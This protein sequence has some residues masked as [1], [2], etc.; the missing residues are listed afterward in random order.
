MQVWG[1]HR[2][3]LA[4]QTQQRGSAAGS[5]VGGC[6]CRDHASIVLKFACYVMQTCNCHVLHTVLQPSERCGLCMATCGTAT[7][8]ITCPL[9]THSDGTSH[10]SLVMVALLVLINR[11]S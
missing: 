11:M 8:D 4:E 3:L 1:R 5:S 9:Y 10:L 2:P 6:V 7:H